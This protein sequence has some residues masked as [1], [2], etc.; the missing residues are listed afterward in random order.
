MAGPC[1]ID[2]DHIVL[3]VTGAP[4]EL[5]ADFANVAGTGSA[6]QGDYTLHIVT[7]HNVT[8][9]QTQTFNLDNSAGVATMSGIIVVTFDPIYLAADDPGET[10]IWHAQLSV[11]GVV[12]D[13]RNKNLQEIP[14]P[15]GTSMW[16]PI[17]VCVGEAS[18]AA[19]DTIPLVFTKTLKM[20]AGS[21]L[22]YGFLMGGDKLV[23]DKNFG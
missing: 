14:V 19:G 2:S 12:V 11:D 5:G 18:V 3:T 13:E 22:Q 10:F 15:D 20:N 7:D 8:H 21:D 6:T 9:T 16:L 1:V 23:V 4:G 17:G